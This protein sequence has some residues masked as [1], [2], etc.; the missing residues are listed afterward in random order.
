[1]LELAR[2]NTELENLGRH[3]TYFNLNEII[4]LKVLVIQQIFI[5]YPLY[6]P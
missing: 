3:T 6:D 5:K 4:Q 2:S 1:M